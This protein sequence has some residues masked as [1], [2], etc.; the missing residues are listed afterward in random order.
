MPTQTK[1]VKFQ[2][3]SKTK[4]TKKSPQSLNPNFKLTSAIKLIKK[5][6]AKN[7][8]TLLENPENFVKTNKMTE[9]NPNSKNPLPKD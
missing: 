2:T 4:N 7:Q 8:K 5:Q 9:A 6:L 3:I 1:L